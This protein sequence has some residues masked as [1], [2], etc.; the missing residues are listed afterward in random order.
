[1]FYVD[2]AISRIPESV[3]GVVSIGVERE[4]PEEVGFAG[5]DLPS[6][7]GMPF[8]EEWRSEKER[9]E[10]KGGRSHGGRIGAGKHGRRAILEDFRLRLLRR[11]ARPEITLSRHWRMS[12]RS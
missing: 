10:K 11:L 6:A 7:V 8:R 1:V 2:L 9:K 4:G 3:P 5:T 12:R